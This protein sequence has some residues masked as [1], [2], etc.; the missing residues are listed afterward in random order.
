MYV[1]QST[2]TKS[3]SRALLTAQHWKNTSAQQQQ[4]WVKSVGTTDYY[5]T[6]KKNKWL[7][8][9]IT[10]M[11][12]TD[13]M[14]SE[15]SLIRKST[16]YVIPLTGRSRTGQVDLWWQIWMVLMGKE[17]EGDFRVLECSTPALSKRNVMQAAHVHNLKFLSSLIARKRL[18]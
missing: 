6:V 14:S 13:L 7:Q 3:F 2:Y 9:A 1:H 16:Y 11:T 17:H 18:I 12:V 4:N 10:W 8:H 15:K 5:R